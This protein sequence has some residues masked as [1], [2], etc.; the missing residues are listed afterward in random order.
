ME[1]TETRKDDGGEKGEY[2]GKETRKEKNLTSLMT[3][4]V[5][6]ISANQ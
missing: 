1:M 2:G 4:D 6:K 5:W 3:W